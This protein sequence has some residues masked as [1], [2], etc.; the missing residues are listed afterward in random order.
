[1]QAGLFREPIHLNI[2]TKGKIRKL[3]REIVIHHEPEV[4]SLVIA[5]RLPIN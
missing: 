3:T 2:A 4:N 1:M 5:G